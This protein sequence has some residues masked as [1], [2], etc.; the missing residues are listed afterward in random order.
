[1]IPVHKSGDV[2]SPF[3]YQPISLT[4]IPCK[5]L[6]HVIYSNLMSFLE[7]NSFFTVYQHGFRK[8]H[9]CETQL[10]TFT[11]DLCSL[12]DLT[13]VVDCVFI[14]FAKAFDCVSHSLLLY[15]L[16]KLNIDTNVLRW[17]EC[18]LHNRFQYVSVNGNESPPCPVTS[19]VP[20]GSVLGP[21]LF[22]LY[23][24]NLPDTIPSSIRLFVYVMSY[25]ER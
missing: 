12:L 20:Q 3:N 13:S 22:L 2:F 1:M 5:L 17:I 25:P 21:L 4:S 14:D 23:M 24:N 18:F 16:S 8:N 9:S 7:S 6:E 19:G 15:K 11:N 10:I